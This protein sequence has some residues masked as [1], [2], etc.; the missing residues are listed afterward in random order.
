MFVSV[1]VP[2]LFDKCNIL[3]ICTS[4]MYM[5]NVSLNSVIVMF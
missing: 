4:V 2:T 1:S 3:R 5:Q